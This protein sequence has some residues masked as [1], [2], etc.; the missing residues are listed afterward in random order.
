M[1]LQLELTLP[2]HFTL[3]SVNSS[4]NAILIFQYFKLVLEKKK[5]QKTFHFCF[6]YGQ[7]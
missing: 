2:K 4:C 7:Q 1:S 6:I 5:Q 3:V